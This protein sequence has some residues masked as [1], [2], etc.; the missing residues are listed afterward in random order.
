MV[1]GGNTQWLDYKGI[2]VQGTFE[3]R[4]CYILDAWK[5]SGRIRD[6]E[7]TNDRIPYVRRD[8]AV[9]TYLLDFKIWDQDGTIRYVEVKGYER[10]NDQEKWT[11]AQH[12]GLGI[13]IWFEKDIVA[14]EGAL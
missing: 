3:L 4:T 1:T 14:Y 12:A 7:Y 5:V 6:W 8:G 10:E 9:S 2:R 11:A 13:E